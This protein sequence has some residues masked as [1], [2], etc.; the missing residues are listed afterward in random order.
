MQ[1]F[2]F[3]L[4]KIKCALFLLYVRNAVLRL[5]EVPAGGFASAKKAPPWQ[6]GLCPGG[7]KALA[8]A[9]DAANAPEQGMQKAQKI[10]CFTKIEKKI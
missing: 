7:G 2:L 9:A 10:P 5:D 6:K 8:N 3:C 4:G 1:S